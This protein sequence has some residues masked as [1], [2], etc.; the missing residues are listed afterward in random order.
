[1]VGV[2]PSGS[3]RVHSSTL[4]FKGDKLRATVAEYYA[5]LSAME[6]VIFGTI[7]VS[8]LAII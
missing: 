1:M 7:Y 6:K 5:S 2:P 3:A 8:G 4:K